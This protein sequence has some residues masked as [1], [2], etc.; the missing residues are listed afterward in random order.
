MNWYLYQA[1][2]PIEHSCTHAP[3]CYLIQMHQYHFALTD[4]SVV[5]RHLKIMKK[6]K[7]N[8]MFCFSALCPGEGRGDHVVWVNSYLCVWETQPGFITM[9][10]CVCP[11]FHPNYRQML[12]YTVTS[13]WTP[14]CSR[15]VKSKKEQSVLTHWTGL[16]WNGFLST[17]TRPSTQHCSRHLK[18]K[19]DRGWL[20]SKWKSGHTILR[21]QYGA[22]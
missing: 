8:Y 13:V 11:H 12:F 6:R 20:V 2:G 5:W 4:I 14:M 1:T 17:V 9:L 15:P 16:A 18:K 22:F 10:H 19:K 21:D 3:K 7:A